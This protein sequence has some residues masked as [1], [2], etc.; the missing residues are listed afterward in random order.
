MLFVPPHAVHAV[1][2]SAAEVLGAQ[3]RCVL[4]RELT[5][6]H[7][8]VLRGTLA[9]LAARF[10]PESGDCTPRGEFTMVVGPDE[11][12]TDRRQGPDLGTE[13]LSAALRAAVDAGMSRSAAAAAIAA[14]LG[15]SRKVCYQLSLEL[16]SEERE[17]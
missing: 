8:E 12:A 13:A 14:A 16:G 7:E 6:L 11:G 4:G 15:V 17:G 1:L 5:K 3:R 10:E 9:E 2:H